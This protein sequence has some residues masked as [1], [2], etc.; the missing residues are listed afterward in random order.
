MFKFKK[1]FFAT[2]L[3]A[4]LAVAALP[5]APAFALTTRNVRFAS[6]NKVSVVADQ[7]A[8][9]RLRG[10]YTCDKPQITSAVSGKV[11]TINV[12]DVKIVG[13]GN[14]C[15]TKQPY[16]R[17]VT[18]GVLVPGKYTVYINS[19]NPGLAAKKLH[20]IAPLIPPTPTPQ[21]SIQ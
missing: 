10:T 20:F 21:V 14:P 3:L 7:P 9:F 2:A 19:T 6:V 16:N 11:I 1:L 12:W 5:A 18:V 15:D 8:A 13:H 4:L 17:V